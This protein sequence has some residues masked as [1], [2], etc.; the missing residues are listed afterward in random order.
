MSLSLFD[1]TIDLG[2]ITV[3]QLNQ[4]VREVIEGEFGPLWVHGEVTSFKAYS[5]GHWY[6]TLRD[7]SSQVRC[8]MW[9]TYAQRHREAGQQPP[10]EGTRV[11]ALATP[12]MWEE[13][14]EFRLSVTKLMA[15]QAM[16]DAALAFER[17]KRLLQAE[18]LFDVARKRPLPEFAGGI[19]VVTSPDGAALRDVI[20]VTRARWPLARIVVVPTS[21][22]GERAPAEIVRALALVDRLEGVDLCIVGRGGGA[23]E[24]LAA[25]ND[26]AVCRALAAVRVPTI[27]AVGHETD[28]SLCDLVADVRAATPS[29]A[30]EL[31]VADRAE[32]LHR[33]DGMAARLAGGLTRRTRLAAER[34]ERSADRMQG[35]LDGL[36]ER[37]RATLERLAAQ[38]DAL[39][40]LK[41]L[42]RGYAMPTGADGRV[43]KR[44]AD[45]PPDLVFNLRVSDGDVRARVE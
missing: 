1:P 17:V 32:V 45:F 5:S 30:A 39:S 27:S 20:S 42:G 21:V 31:A 34:L 10:A 25:F 33:V 12:G 37:R 18:G 24:D 9:R 26:E 38:L 41:V 29:N 19:A 22:Q 16:G 28:V 4:A 8:C 23:R 13:K 43:L 11:F 14:G 3:S 44:R 36:R 15:T 6:F 2:A 40:P 7:E 35:A